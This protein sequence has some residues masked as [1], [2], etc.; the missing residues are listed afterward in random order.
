MHMTTDWVLVPSHSKDTHCRNCFW[1]GSRHPL[2]GLSQLDLVDK[3]NC[4][5]NT[6]ITSEEGSSENLLLLSRQRHL[7]LNTGICCLGLPL[8]GI[9]WSLSFACCCA[10]QTCPSSFRPSCS[11]TPSTGL[12]VL[13]GIP[14]FLS[15]IPFIPFNHPIFIPNSVCLCFPSLSPV[16]SSF[17]LSFL[18]K[19]ICTFCFV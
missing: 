10:V 19:S 1:L 6:K 16:N 14:P 11:S 3:S 9:S 8:A 15:I 13:A 4:R 5:Q 18:F 12:Q 17:P 2:H 7:A